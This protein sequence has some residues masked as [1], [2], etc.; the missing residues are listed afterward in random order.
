MGSIE[1]TPETVGM[2]GKKLPIFRMLGL[3]SNVEIGGL[4]DSSSIQSMDVR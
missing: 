2:L 1:D 4:V 3:L